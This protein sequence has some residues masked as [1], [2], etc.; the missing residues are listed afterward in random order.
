VAGAQRW[1]AAATIAFGVAL[2][3]TGDDPDLR[4]ATNDDGGSIDASGV[5]DASNADGSALDA[6]PRCN[7]TAPFQ[8]PAPMDGVGSPDHELSASLSEDELT[9]YFSRRALDAGSNSELYVTTRTSRDATFGP[10][11]LLAIVNSP[12]E[13]DNITTTGDA[14]TVYFHSSRFD[15]GLAP[16]DIFRAERPSLITSLSPATPV[17]I[18]T[19][20]FDGD[21]FI[22]PDGKTLYFTST[23]SGPF[24]IY[25]S[26]QTAD[27]GFE[28][29]IELSE[30]YA[31]DA[32]QSDIGQP[33]VAP[34]GR[35]LY[36]A[37]GVNT[38]F[39]VW[40]A[41]RLD[42]LGAFSS[43]R[44]VENVNLSTANDVPSWVSRDGCLLV[45]RS[46][47]PGGSGGED[48][49]LAKRGF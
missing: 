41:T 31:V 21:P 35:A 27:G 14:L 2:A 49:W 25:R 10:P 1:M 34:D 15:G 28:T 30:L 7:P 17:G 45:F 44:P 39:D 36:F 29:A 12:Y 5:D 6:G 23:R 9:M 22:M 4:A 18:N 24:R 13:D 8:T 38:N 16:P 26:E 20:A 46:N 33:I 3:C 43:L 19:P 32:G 11:T 42:T 48:L 37:S 47:R 40:V